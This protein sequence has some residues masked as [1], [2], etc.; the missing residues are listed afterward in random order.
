MIAVTDPDRDARGRFVKGNQASKKGWQAM[1]DRHFGGDQ[2]AAVEW[3]VA[4]GQFVADEI[5]KDAGFYYT[6]PDPGPHPAW[7]NGANGKNEAR[8][9]V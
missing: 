1:V 6:Q 5:Y 3:L 2:R 4:R 7:V 8:N 9:S